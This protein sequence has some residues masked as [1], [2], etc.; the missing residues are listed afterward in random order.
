MAEK[1][2]KRSEIDDKFKWKLEDTYA[3]DD[4]WEADFLELKKK[5]E[6]MKKYKGNLTSTADNFKKGLELYFSIDRLLDKVA[7]YSYRR[8]DEDLN[9]AKYQE[10]A[11]RIDTLYSE[12]SSETVFVTTELSKMEPESFDGFAREN[13]N[14]ELYRFYMDEI[15]RLKPHT[16]SDEEEKILA[17]ASEIAGGAESTYGMLNNADIKFPIFKDENGNEIELTKGNYIKY[18]QSGN[19][20]VRK[21][22]FEKFYKT[23]LAYKNTFVSTLNSNVKTHVFYT[24]SRKYESALKRSLFQ[25]NVNTS[26]YENLISTI[27]SNFDKIHK[28][29]EVRKKY[30]K[31][32]E[33]HMY[34]IYVP[35]LKEIDK[36]IPYKEAVTMVKDAL[37]ILGED[38]SN[39][40]E[41]AFTDGWIDIYENDGKRS[42]AYSSGSYDSKPYILLNHRDDLDSVFTLAHEMGHSMHSYYS[43][44]NQPYIYSQYKIFV[45]EVAST[46][47][48][49]LL[50]K[51]M[52]KKAETKQEKMYLLNHF[53]DQFKATMYRQVQFAE[54]EKMIHEKV[55]A[56]EALSA[57]KVCQMY[58]ELNKMYYGDNVISDDYIKVEWARIPHFY[59]NFYVYK[60]AT[61]FSAAVDIAERI[62]SGDKIALENYLKFLKSGGSDYP[63][64]LLKIAGVDMSTTEPVQN[65]LNVFAKL[66][67]EFEEL[68]K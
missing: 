39:I 5:T 44:K 30:L 55:E 60:Y 6:E 15:F 25:D 67:E 8:K 31:L 50:M 29:Y 26:L 47:N 62:S 46:V 33:Q 52:L 56:G 66:I 18:M 3:S 34:D 7:D 23:Y 13:K 42:G 45:A 53:M 51:H 28:Y 21:E 17:M 43:K 10:M 59:Y 12:I 22:V 54:F 20:E 40:M 14:I 36:Q 35:M 27:H 65:A 64:E 48:E 58:L 2:K 41:H 1:L 49:I 38:Y 32:E 57:D 4:L 11:D 19:R 9:V 61:G 63:I 16:L 24:K 37:K 68:S